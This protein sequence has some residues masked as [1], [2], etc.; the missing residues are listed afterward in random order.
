MNSLE[1]DALKFLYVTPE[2]FNRQLIYNEREVDDLSQLRPAFLVVDEAHCVDRW[3]GD[4]RPD[5]NRIGEIRSLLG[6]PP[7]LAFTATAGRQAQ[8][9]ILESLRIPEAKRLVTGADRP[10]IAL[11]RHRMQMSTTSEPKRPGEA[12]REASSVVARQ[13]KRSSSCRP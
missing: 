10:N 3:G 7:V 9:R 8:D 1:E 13:A 5:Y 2:R 6:D 4:F 11:V 12:N